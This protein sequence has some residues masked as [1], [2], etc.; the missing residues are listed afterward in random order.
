MRYHPRSSCGSQHSFVGDTEFGNGEIHVA[1]D[2]VIAVRGFLPG[3]VLPSRVAQLLGAVD[4][5]D[6]PEAGCRLLSDSRCGDGIFPVVKI[7]SAMP[8]E[9]GL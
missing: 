4:S 2:V 7:Y 9:H 8:K 6:V 5:C 1:G 3:G